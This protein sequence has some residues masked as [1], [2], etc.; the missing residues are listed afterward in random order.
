MVVDKKDKTCGACL[1][2]EK[3][4]QL[5]S[6]TRHLHRSP[7]SSNPD[8]ELGAFLLLQAKKEKTTRGGVLSLP[9]SWRC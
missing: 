8:D 5:K 6:L 9:P 3:N 4:E 7:K 1:E 2:L